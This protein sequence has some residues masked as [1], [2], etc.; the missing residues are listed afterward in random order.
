[1]QMFYLKSSVR[2]KW[3]VFE[4]FRLSWTSY[5]IIYLISMNDTWFGVF[6]WH[7][8]G[9]R[10]FHVCVKWRIYFLKRWKYIHSKLIDNVSSIYFFVVQFLIIKWD[11]FTSVIVSLVDVWSE[12]ILDTKSVSQVSFV[13]TLIFDESLFP[14]LLPDFLLSVERVTCWISEKCSV[15]T[16]F[17]NGNSRSSIL[18]I[19]LSLYYVFETFIISTNSQKLQW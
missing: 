2:R 13:L 10:T 8:Y 15:F 1:M 14:R 17:F 5:L 18:L 7:N 11:I 4:R 19:E 9:I 3:G 16:W 6:P 12:E